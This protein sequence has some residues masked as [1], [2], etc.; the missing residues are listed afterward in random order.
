MTEFKSRLRVDL[1]G[2]MKNPDKL[3]ITTLR[4]LLAAIQNEELSGKQAR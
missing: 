4:M 1:T 2:A 3:R